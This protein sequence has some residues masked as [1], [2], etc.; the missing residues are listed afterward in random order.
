MDY[1][2]NPFGGTQ[3]YLCSAC[4]V[5]HALVFPAFGTWITSQTPLVVHE[6]T[7]VLPVL[8]TTPLFFEPLV[9][10]LP[11]KPLWWYTKPP[12]FSLL[13]VPRPCF[14]TRWYMDYPQNPF[15]GTRNQLCSACSVYHT[16]VFQAFGTW[17]TLKT[18]WW[19]TKLPVFSLFCVPHPCFSS[20]W[21]MDY[22]RNPFG[23]TRN[24]LCSACSVYHALVFRAVGTWIT[25]ETPLVVHRLA[26]L[27]NDK[28]RSTPK[29]MA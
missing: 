3:N 29:K 19:Y 8:C 7:C 15:G 14:S 23:G 21:Y 24:Y 18:L 5:Y 12:L 26:T 9:H 17:I 4:S 13:C 27:R 11:P 6:T 2:R 22:P 1:P 16:L 25:L 20:R 28:M 10:G